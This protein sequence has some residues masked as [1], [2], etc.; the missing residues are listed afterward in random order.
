MA[1]IREKKQDGKTVSY[2]FTC[3]VGRDARGTQI[4]RYATWISPQDMTPG[5]ARKAAEK[6][7]QSWEQKMK[8][9]FSKDLNNPERSRIKDL[10]NENLDFASFIAKVWFPVQIDSGV[11]K[12]KTVSYY[13]DTAKN[14]AAYFEGCGIKNIGSIS[15]QRF[16]VYLRTERGYSPQYV[17]HHYRA[18]KMIFDFAEEHGV[19]LD[20]PM[21]RVGK[22]KLEKKTVDAMSEAEARIF[23][24][25]LENCPIDF[26]CL[27]QLLITTGLRRG[28]VV[29]LKWRDIDQERT[30]LTVERNVVYTATSGIV[31]NTPKTSAGFRTIP[32]LS[33]TVVLLQQ[34]KELRKREYPDA[35]L[36]DS[37][38]FP[39]KDDLFA[40]RDPDAVT[41]RIKRFMER[42]GLPSYSAHDI[43]HSCAT[44]LLSAGADVK[45]VQQ[46][47]GHTRAST[48]LDFYVKSD[49]KQMAAAADKMAKEFG[50]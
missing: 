23:F 22:P 41:R 8:A 13:N 40:P 28:E 44:L 12:A 30:A 25:A 26:R 35:L 49:I 34:L 32:L 48:T 46:I 1:S 5:R 45:S 47:L 29:D 24:S 43:R 38:V 42:N 7:A 18:L 20:N 3:C 16:L 37:F 39:S 2:Q 11:Y 15:I 27:L 50:L 17:Q 33:S 21:D 36:A 9:E 31:I 19:V 6:E 10:S 4:R 14:I